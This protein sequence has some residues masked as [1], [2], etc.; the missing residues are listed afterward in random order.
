M[1]ALA[2]F[3]S[4]AALLVAYY[5]V[6]DARQNRHHDATLRIRLDLVELNHRIEVL[7]AEFPHL[8]DWVLALADRHPELEAGRAAVLAE[9]YDEF[10]SRLVKLDENLTGGLP[11]M[12]DLRPNA[13]ASVSELIEVSRNGLIV[14]DDAV[15]DGHV[16]IEQIKAD[17]SP[18]KN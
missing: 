17:L 10:L 4:I 7:K 9:R 6:T 3:I 11:S 5:A 18:K 1:D 15:Q 14:F 12:D 13:I 2:L 16:L 8:R